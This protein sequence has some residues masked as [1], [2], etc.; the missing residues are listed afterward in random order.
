MRHNPRHRAQQWNK[1]RNYTDLT[2]ALRITL[3]RSIEPKRR[4]LRSRWHQHKFELP[5]GLH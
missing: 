1:G 3:I 2:N 5:P 4:P